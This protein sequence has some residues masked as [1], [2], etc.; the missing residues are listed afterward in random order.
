MIVNISAQ[1][2]LVSVQSGE[3]ER[4]DSQPRACFGKLRSLTLPGLHRCGSG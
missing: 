3:R 4:P 2:R 1:V